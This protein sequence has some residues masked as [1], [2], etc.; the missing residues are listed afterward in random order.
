MSIWEKLAAAVADVS[1]G[2][3]MGGWFSDRAAR[4][5]STEDALP[6]TVGMI[7]LGAKM[8]KADGVVIKD[9]VVAFK[10]VFKVSDAEM[11]NAARVFNRQARHDRLRNMCRATC[12][13]VQW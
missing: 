9:E 10:K 4:R 7:T 6:F 11:G 3:G 12:H 1:T 2:A 8:A 13:L 5:V